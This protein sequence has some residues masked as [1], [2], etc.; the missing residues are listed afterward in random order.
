MIKYYTYVAESERGPF[1][2]GETKNPANRML[3][4]RT[5]KGAKFF[6]MYKFKELRMLTE[7]D[8]LSEARREEN[9]IKKLSRKEKIILIENRKNET[10][11]LKKLFDI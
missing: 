5:G 3:L 8:T 7:F 10:K 1:Y 9:R 2:T 4:H 11:R 6:R